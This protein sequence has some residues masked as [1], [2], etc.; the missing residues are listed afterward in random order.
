MFRRI[1]SCTVAL[2][3]ASCSP[4]ITVVNHSPSLA[5]QEAQ[6]F[7]QTA[8]IKHDFQKAYE[9]F[10]ESGKTL[11]SFD[12]FTEALRSCHPIAFPLSVTAT[13][14]EPIHGQRG[15]N[16]Y[17]LGENG[18]EKFYYRFSMEGVKETGYKVCGFWRH[19]GPYPPSSSRIRLDQSL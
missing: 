18:N 14:Y 11:T 7:A 15:M 8:L 17:L 2:A 1:L 6:T 9:L 4:N 19:D 3:I 10:G 13:E 16:I 5:V 12:Q